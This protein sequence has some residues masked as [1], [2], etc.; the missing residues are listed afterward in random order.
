LSPIARLAETAEGRA[1]LDANLAVTGG[2]QAGTLAQPLLLPLPEQRALALKDCF[3][4][5]G[6]ATQLADG[7]GTRL[8][9][10][11]QAKARY[12]EPKS[13]TSLSPA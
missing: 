9:E 13:F 5:D 7:L 6:N 4:T 12:T 11:Y 2:I 1:A 10:A 3:I 8:A